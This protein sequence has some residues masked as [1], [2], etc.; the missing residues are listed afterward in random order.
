M[1]GRLETGF[2]RNERG[3]TGQETKDP[4][5]VLKHKGA[6]VCSLVPVLGGLSQVACL[7]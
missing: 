1:E 4:A 3:R 5:S 2:C 7:L 6:L